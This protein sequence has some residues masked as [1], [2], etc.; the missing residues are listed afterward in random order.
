MFSGN[1]PFCHTAPINQNFVLPDFKFS[2]ISP[3]SINSFLVNGQT[4]LLKNKLEH[5]TSKN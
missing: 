2:N 3:T 5:T 4:E 1:N